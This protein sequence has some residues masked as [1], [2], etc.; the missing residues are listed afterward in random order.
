[1]GAEETA[2]NA[3]LAT[4]S[5]A[6]CDSILEKKASGIHRELVNAIASCYQRSSDATRQRVNRFPVLRSVDLFGRCNII[7]KMDGAIHRILPLTQSDKYSSTSSISRL[8]FYFLSVLF[9][10]T[11]LFLLLR[12]NRMPFWH[13]SMHFLFCSLLMASV[14]MSVTCG[15]RVADCWKNCQ[16]P[17]GCS[18]ASLKYAQQQ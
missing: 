15:G 7:H 11:C 16:Q 2:T 8:V 17:L 12:D 18:L 6:F 13:I 1:M 3:T 9:V 14:T 5:P 4:L 10:I